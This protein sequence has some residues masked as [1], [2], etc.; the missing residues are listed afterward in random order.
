MSRKRPAT[1]KSKE[2]EHHTERARSNNY[3]GTGC[4]SRRSFENFVQ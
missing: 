3:G 1:K 2:E 4:A